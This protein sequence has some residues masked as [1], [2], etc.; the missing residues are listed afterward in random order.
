M[1]DS[2]RRTVC[3]ELLVAGNLLSYSELYHVT[4]AN[5]TLMD[6]EEQ[7]RLM[8]KHLSAAEAAERKGD[9]IVAFNARRYLAEQFQNSG[10][11]H[12]S[13]H[14]WNTC[15][16]CGQQLDDNGTILVETHRAI[17]EKLFQEGT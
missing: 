10:D 17:A 7:L 15:L 14:F 3:L 11:V 4:E 13:Q 1:D 12:V 6:N 16:D 9:T 8:Q 2:V 5:P